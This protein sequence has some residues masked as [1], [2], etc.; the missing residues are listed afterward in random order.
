M[1]RY[2][3][4]QTTT[5][6]I[7]L[8]TMFHVLAIVLGFYLLYLIWN[9]ILILFA[10]IILAALIDPFASR[11]AK[12]RVPRGL[13]ILCIYVVLGGLFT[14]AFGL[15]T[16]VVTE[17][18][19]QLIENIT[20]LTADLRDTPQIHAFITSLEQMGI[21]L[22][23]TPVA[24]ENSSEAI[25]SVFGAVSNVFKGFG[26]IILILVIAFYMVAEDDPLRKIVHN[27]VPSK[28]VGYI[29]SLLQRIRDK[30]TFWIRGQL[31]LSFAVGIFTFIGLSILGVKYAAALALIAALL[32]FI[33]YLGPILSSIPAAI[34][35]FT[36][37]GVVLL[38]FVL[39]MYTVVQQIENNILAPKIMQKAIGLNP[40]ISII[41][42]LVGVQLGG[43]IGALIA[44]PAA[45]VLSVVLRDVFDSTR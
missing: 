43:I 32:E 31:V 7:S 27:V 19:P 9:I 37:G 3:C 14:L 28:H 18:V 22:D 42:I 25:S 6:H 16:P 4:M 10:A 1:P 8:R 20:T 24:S 45:T 38:V 11:L 15:L 23:Y 39:I 30:L 41:A 17:D 5:T 33:P 2:Y 29:V 21:H 12:Y 26:T 35:G 36:Q 44:I 34:I 13:S 40:V